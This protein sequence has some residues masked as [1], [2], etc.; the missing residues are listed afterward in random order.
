MVPYGELQHPA[1]RMYVPMTESEVKEA[2]IILCVYAAGINGSRGT[3]SA[4]IAVKDDVVIVTKKFLL[5]NYCTRLQ[6]SLLSVWK[7]LDWLYKWME[8]TASVNGDIVKVFVQL[9]SVKGMMFGTSY[10]RLVFESQCLVRDML[11]KFG[12][13]V[14]FVYEGKPRGKY[15]DMVNSAAIAACSLKTAPAYDMFEMKYARIKI[16]MKMHEQWNVWYLSS[17]QGSGLKEFFTSVG[18]AQKF[19]RQ[20]GWSY[21]LT[22]ALT[23]HGCFRAY[24]HRFCLIDDPYCGCDDVSVQDVKHLLFECKNLKDDRKVWRSQCEKDGVDYSMNGFREAVE[25]GKG[26]KVIGEC[27]KIMVEYTIEMNE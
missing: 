26:L 27:L 22:Q 24:L 1:F 7:S 25:K 21:H 12:V 14:D 11:V 5:S 18:L 6:A 10:N 23:G 8:K 9:S 19:I 15:P 17:A 16:R 2:K 20:C 4:F 3:G 13:K